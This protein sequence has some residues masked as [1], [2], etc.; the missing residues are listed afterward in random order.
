MKPY[1]K[2]L[3]PFRAGVGD[4]DFLLRHLRSPLLGIGFRV[5]GSGP[6]LVTVGFRCMRPRST[7]EVV[8]VRVSSAK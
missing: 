7:G 3:N 1:I 5:K 6:Y 4:P 2:T 8:I